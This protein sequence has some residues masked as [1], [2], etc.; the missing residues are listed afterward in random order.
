MTQKQKTLLTIDGDGLI[1]RAHFGAGHEYLVG[2]QK[3]GGVYNA[4]RK[5]RNMITTWDADAFIIGFDPN[6]P[7]TFRHKQYAGYKAK[8]PPKEEDHIKAKELFVQ[9]M[10][11]MGAAVVMDPNFEADDV[12]NTSAVIATNMGWRAV[13]AS[14]DKDMLVMMANPNV[15]IQPPYANE[16]FTRDDFD[17][18]YFGIL[19]EQ[20]DDFLAMQ[21]DEVDNIPGITQCGPKRSA[22]FLLKYKT[23][24]GIHAAALNGEIKGE[25][26]KHIINDTKRALAFRDFLKLRADVPNVPTPDKAIFGEP[27]Y[28]ALVATF[29]KLGFMDLA[30]EAQEGLQQQSQGMSM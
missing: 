21:G 6:G 2:T 23:I 5:V 18:K 27:N 29:T 4:I 26:G 19:P 3:V 17:K 11:D 30:R 14:K 25:V 22:Q 15:I 1:A 13:V 16:R 8:R 12:V 9:I 10:K 7:T 20:M 28:Q 24:E